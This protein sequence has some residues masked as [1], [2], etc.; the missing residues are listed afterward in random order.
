[1][2]LLYVFEC[3]IVSDLFFFSIPY[4][5][6]IVLHNRYV[7]KRKK[8]EK[9]EEVDVVCVGISIHGAF[10]KCLFSEKRAVV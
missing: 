9:P 5:D 1:M 3:R 8:K 6:H 2:A 4:F 7:L 10:E